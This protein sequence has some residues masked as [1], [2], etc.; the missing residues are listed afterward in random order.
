MR[1]FKT[2]LSIRECLERS[3]FDK[4]IDLFCNAL[5]KAC[6]N[7]RDQLESLI[8]NIKD[9]RSKQ[10]KQALQIILSEFDLFVISMRI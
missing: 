10:E 3:N 1:W 2:N 9:K 6:K 7:I 4:D 5:D 8:H